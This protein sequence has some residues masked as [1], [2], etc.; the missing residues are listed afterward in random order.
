MQTLTFLEVRKDHDLASMVG[1][2][3][4][5]ELWC[6]IVLETHIPLDRSIIMSCCSGRITAPYNLTTKTICRQVKPDRNI[7]RF[8]DSDTNTSRYVARSSK[9][10]MSPHFHSSRLLFHW[11]RTRNQILLV[12][13]LVLDPNLL[14]PARSLPGDTLC[15]VFSVEQRGS[16]FESQ[17]FRLYDEEIAESQLECDPAT[18]H[19]LRSVRA[20][21]PSCI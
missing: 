10:I 12:I 18:V 6:S 11:G 4:C 17:A 9:H 21:F 3:R 5:L 16:L 13:V 14:R 8:H 15:C 1:L 20:L 2:L 7:V 19:N